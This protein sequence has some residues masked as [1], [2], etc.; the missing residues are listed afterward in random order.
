MDPAAC[1]ERTGISKDELFEKDVQPTRGQEIIAI[2]NFVRLSPQKVG[3]GVAV[4]RRLHIGAFGIWGFAIIT[5]PTLR[6]AI[7]TAIS[8]ANLSYVLADMTLIEDG[9]D[10][11][12]EF[13]MSDLPEAIRLYVLER[14]C[15]VAMTFFSDFIQE[16]CFSDFRVLS[17]LSDRACAEQL[18]KLLNIEVIDGANVGALQF[19]T[20]MLDEPLPKSD[21]VTQQYCIDQ[22][23]A[24]LGRVNGS[25]PSWSLKVRDTLIEGL[26]TDT[27]VDTVA[28]QLNVTERTLRR[29]LKEEGATYRQIYT[30]VRL[31]L[32]RE[33]LETAGLT[34]DSVSWRVGYS[35]SAGF[36]RAFSR[37]FGVTPGAVR[38]KS[39]KMN[40]AQSA[41]TDA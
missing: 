17:T 21:P 35:E 14:H 18:S 16:Q 22:C 20:S 4:G 32:A 38:A 7:N 12:L 40:S 39:V 37:K 41:L 26:G 10:A 11:R 5:S 3:L 19:P 30:D 33:L 31:T 8:F 9:T 36:V 6:A 27:K 24:L 1:L 25:L 13:D 34:V 15:C 29:R 23:K 28:R 2:E